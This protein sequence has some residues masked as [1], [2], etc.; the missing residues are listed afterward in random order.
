MDTVFR[1]WTEAV[2]YLN[3]KIK[4]AGLIAGQNVQLEDTGQGIRISSCSQNIRGNVYNGYFKVIKTA[5][6]KLKIV[7]GTDAEAENCF[8]GY[9]N[10]LQKDIPATEL[11]ITESGIVYLESAAEG[12][13]A[14]D[15]ACTFKQASELPAFEDGK[16]FTL[17]SRVE[18]AD[19]KITGFTQEYPPNHIIVWGVC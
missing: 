16:E 6:N 15:F 13:P 10:K 9:I 3:E 17:I 2:S 18:L 11:V 4:R 19:E 1:K 7:D 14:T 12:D 8:S 5:A